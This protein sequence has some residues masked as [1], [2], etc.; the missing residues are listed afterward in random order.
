MIQWLRLLAFHAAG[1]SSIPGQETIIRSQ[2]LHG[3]AKLKILS[4]RG[5]YNWS[6]TNID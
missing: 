2:M 3:V 6:G 5:F 1:G 4:E